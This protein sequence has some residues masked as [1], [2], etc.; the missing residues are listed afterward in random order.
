[1]RKE[2]A[3]TLISTH[4]NWLMMRWSQLRL[5]SVDS[6]WTIQLCSVQD[7]STQNV[8]FG[9]KK[10]FKYILWKYQ[11]LAEI[12]SR[13]G[14]NERRLIERKHLQQQ[15]SVVFY[16][17][18]TGGWRPAAAR[19]WVFFLV[20]DCSVEVFHCSRN[21]FMRLISDASMSSSVINILRDCCFLVKYLDLGS[22]TDQPPAVSAWNKIS[23]CEPAQEMGWVSI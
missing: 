14:L 8:Q 17:V 22:L 19:V 11:T 7:S 23:F 9:I 4:F 13:T 2:F 21:M 18:K 3:R 20:S 15:H 10:Y 1:M 12:F 6:G 16:N 5:W